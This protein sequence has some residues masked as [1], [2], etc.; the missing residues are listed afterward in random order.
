MALLQIRIYPDPILRKKCRE[1]AGVGDEEKK[2]LDDMAETMRANHGVGLAGPQVGILQR[3]IVLDAGESLLKMVNPKILSKEGGSRLEE[4]C[5]SVI[6]KTVNIKRAEEISVSF[7]DETGK[8]C[9][10]MF[11]GLTARVIQHEI[12]HLDGK[13]IIDYLPWY[14]RLCK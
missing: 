13:L 14:K 8:E 12:E 9:V 5:L 3:I 11:S 2:F 4:G 1:I 10:E 7:V 6:D